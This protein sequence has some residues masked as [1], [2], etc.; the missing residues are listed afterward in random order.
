VQSLLG[1][2][3]PVRTELRL[4]NVAP[5]NG[6]ALGTRRL[7]V[8]RIQEHADHGTRTLPATTSLPIAPGFPR[9]RSR[10]CADHLQIIWQRHLGAVLCENL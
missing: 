9:R 5:F 8:R 7:R 6:V 1:A 4:G 2:R 3:Q 10:A